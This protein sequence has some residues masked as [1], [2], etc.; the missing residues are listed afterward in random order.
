MKGGH[1]RFLSLVLAVVALSL[2]AC[3]QDTVVQ[4]R[5]EC[6]NGKVLIATFTNGKQVTIESDS[7]SFN[8]PRVEA[9]SGTKY[10]SE[11]D[12]TVFWSKGIDAAFIG[13][14]GV[15]PLSCRRK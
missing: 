4:A 3:E 10:E 5:Y 12:G 11:A 1:Y 6:N 7:L 15:A 14:N 2:G 8:L 9:T 13:G